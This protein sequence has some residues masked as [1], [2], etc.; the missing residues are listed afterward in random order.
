VKGNKAVSIR[1]SK[2]QAPSTGEI[3][4]IKQQ[5]SHASGIG[6]LRIGIS[7]VLGC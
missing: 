5:M 6:C 2:Y 4:N 3:P 1:S 7:L